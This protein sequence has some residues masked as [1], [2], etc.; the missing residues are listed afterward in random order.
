MTVELSKVIFLFFVISISRKI[1]RADAGVSGTARAVMMSISTTTVAQL[2]LLPAAVL[3]SLLA[4]AEAASQV[5][6]PAFAAL[7]H[8][9][10]YEG[11]GDEAVFALPF[12]MISSASNE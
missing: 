6:T 4:V 2:T 1:C 3:V 11:V 7:L 8:V 9:C 10:E 5:D 12:A